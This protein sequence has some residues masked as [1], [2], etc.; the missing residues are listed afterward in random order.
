MTIAFQK[1]FILELVTWDYFLWNEH[2]KT[3]LQL[4]FLVQIAS[5]DLQNVLLQRDG[6]SINIWEEQQHCP[7]SL[8]NLKSISTSRFHVW[9]HFDTCCKILCLKL[10]TLPTCFSPSGM[11]SPQRSH[12]SQNGSSHQNQRRLPMIRLWGLFLL[13][14]PNRNKE[15]SDFL[16]KNSYD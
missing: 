16:E 9:G 6:V 13:C 10:T 3:I 1:K 5:L 4:R 15:Q 12:G 7:C 2:A 14:D 11:L 8:C